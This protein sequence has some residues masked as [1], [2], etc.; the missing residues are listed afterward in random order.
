MISAAHSLSL[1]DFFIFLKVLQFCRVEDRVYAGGVEGVADLEACG[2]RVVDG[3]T[4]DTVYDILVGRCAVWVPGRREL[5]SKET[6]GE[7]IDA[8]LEACLID[9]P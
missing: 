8:V 1:D 6:V 3:I 4:I 2:C 9:F 5:L 7:V